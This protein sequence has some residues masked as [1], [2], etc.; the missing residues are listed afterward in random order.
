MH[1]IRL[2]INHFIYIKEDNYYVIYSDVSIT[3]SIAS[4]K[5]IETL[6]SYVNNV[7]IILFQSQFLDK[8]LYFLILTALK[9]RYA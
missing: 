5:T 4:N 9:L 7:Y 1:I 3:R 6:Q 8:F 2:Y